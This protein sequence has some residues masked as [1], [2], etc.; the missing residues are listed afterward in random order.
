MAIL[1]VYTAGAQ[2]TFHIVTKDNVT[3]APIKGVS[4]QSNKITIYTND[5]GYAGIKNISNGVR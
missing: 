2:N 5:K 4:I 1:F 3:K